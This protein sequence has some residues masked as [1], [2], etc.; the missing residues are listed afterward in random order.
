MF[1]LN[2]T[3]RI[4]D[5]DKEELVNF[6]DDSF[7]PELL[8]STER[9]KNPCDYYKNAI[10]GWGEGFLEERPVEPSDL[11][12]Y[13]VNSTTTFGHQNLVGRICLE[14]V[15]PAFFEAFPRGVIML[16]EL[17]ND[18]VERMWDRELR[19]AETMGYADSYRDPLAIPQGMTGLQ[20]SNFP[21]NVLLLTAW[22]IYPFTL[23][24]YVHTS[25]DIVFLF[26]P[27]R[28]IRH[29]QMLEGGA[30]SHLLW[31]MHHIFDDQWTFDGRGPKSAA[32]ESQFSPNDK[33]PLKKDIGI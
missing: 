8:Q 9:D 2:R 30:F 4:T 32:P 5:L 26:V 17:S 24:D 25:A 6:L 3:I 20:P 14:Y 16:V 1:K 27:D 7:H 18:W 33:S 12:S 28:P 11:F 10:R 13:I 23:L 31:R 15:W 29:A 22:G 21:L 19:L